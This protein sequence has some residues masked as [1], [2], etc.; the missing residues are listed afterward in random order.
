MEAVRSTGIEKRRYLIWGVVLC[1]FVIGL[2]HRLSMGALADFLV[3]ELNYSG[4]ALGFLTS[5]TFYAYA[6]MQIPAGFL[7]DWLG[8]RKVCGVGLLLTASGSL[9]FSLTS[10]IWV[11]I[12]GRVLVGVGNSGMMLSAFKVQADLFEPRQFPALSGIT[13]CCANFGALLAMFPFAV[14]VNK[15][16]W[17][18]S[19]YLTSALTIALSIAVFLI[20]PKTEKTPSLSVKETI[21]RLK[22]VLTNK[23]IWPPFGIMF[24]IMGIMTILKGL[25]GI[26]YVMHVYSLD[27]VAASRLLC[28]IPIGFM[29]CGPLLGKICEKV[30]GGVRTVSIVGSSLV[31]V[32]MLILVLFRAK[33]PESIMPIFF[34][35]VGFAG[36][37]HILAFTKAKEVSPV[38]L[39]GIATAVVNMGE[40]IGSSILG[41]IFGR[42]L[43]VGWQGQMVNNSR[44]YSQD[45][46]T[47]VFAI[48]TVLSIIAIFCSYKFKK[49]NE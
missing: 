43:D 1:A 8:V 10:T 47:I 7:L 28:M 6:L 49:A 15:M 44:V 9:M 34:I 13:S 12:L 2:I 14:L 36:V 45:S 42:I 39:A 35:F 4:A 18:E 27:N 17:R 31:A 32:S 38:A 11:A 37:T 19:F 5:A 40:F 29:I 24:T 30:K 48:A 25:W 20:V 3:R 33:P 22:N 41:P 21:N 23:Q 16:G 26:P 46:Y